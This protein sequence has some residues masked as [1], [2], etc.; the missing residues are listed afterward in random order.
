M[1]SG[2]EILVIGAR[3]MLGGELARLLERSNARVVLAD[4]RAG[5]K[6]VYLDITDSTAVGHAIDRFHPRVVINCSAYTNV[7]GAES[8]YRTAFAV[9]SSGPRNLAKACA[10][11]GAKLIHFSTDYVYNGQAGRQQPIPEDEDIEPL[12]VYGLSKAFGDELIRSFLPDDH[13][14]LRTSWLHGS[15]GPNF[16]HTMLK[17]GREKEQIAVVDD[18]FGS[19]TWTGWLAETALKLMQRGF[20]GIYNASSRGNI[21]WFDFAVEIFKQ[22]EMNVKVVR[23]TTAQLNRPAPRPAYSTLDLRKLE[24]ALGEPCIDWRDGLR[25]HLDALREEERR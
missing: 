23:Q 1:F 9:N 16:V 5:D 7:D 15:G 24:E 8:D 21:S 19:P 18:Q 22:T 17:L 4:I 14:I 6:T 3:G 11:S 25:A 10:A 12:G 13:L 20:C 2:G